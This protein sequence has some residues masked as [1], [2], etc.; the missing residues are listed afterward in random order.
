MSEKRKNNRVKRFRSMINQ[1]NVE[2]DNLE[3]EIKKLKREKEELKMQL[4]NGRN[5]HNAALLMIHQ[6]DA[7]LPDGWEKQFCSRLNR[8]YY[9]H[10]TRKIHFWCK[11]SVGSSSS[12]SSHS[13]SESGES[14]CSDSDSTN[15]LKDLHQSDFNK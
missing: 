13:E 4:K 10:D 11:N 15:S 8:Y 9:V 7:T 3:Q 12:D 6:L 1:L 2:K 5:E 14:T